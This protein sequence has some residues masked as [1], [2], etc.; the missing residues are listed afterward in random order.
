MDSRRVRGESPAGEKALE[1]RSARTARTGEG[2]AFGFG[3]GLAG[4]ALLTSLRPRRRSG[5][6]AMAA[7]TA[8]RRPNGG[9]PGV[10]GD[11]MAVM[12]TPFFSS[13]HG[14]NSGVA[15]SGLSAIAPWKA[16]DWYIMAA[17]G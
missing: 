16:G 12:V 3:D 8:A 1:W 11:I 13:A 17:L 14:E 5:N 6:V 4:R 15:G 9:E 7:A 10:P 2:D